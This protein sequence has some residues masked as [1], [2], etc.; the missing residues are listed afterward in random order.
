MRLFGTF[1]GPALTSYLRLS[2]GAPVQFEQ[3]LNDGGEQARAELAKLPGF[4]AASDAATTTTSKRTALERME[5]LAVDVLPVVDEQ[6][7]FIGTVDRAKLTA[8]LILDV[9]RRLEEK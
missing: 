8:A 5:K 4:V 3:L 6:Q 1:S 9:T 7:R 2:D